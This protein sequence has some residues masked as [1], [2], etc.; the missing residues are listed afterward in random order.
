MKIVAFT[1][2]L[3]A[4]SSGAQAGWSLVGAS[5]TTSYYVD[6]GTV[7]KKGIFTRMWSLYNYAEPIFGKDGEQYS[8]S[9]MH[10]EYDCSEERSKRLFTSVYKKPMGE[11]SALT[12]KHSTPAWGPIPPGTAIELQWKLACDQR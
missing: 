12:L 1:L 4:F 9:I 8:S 2:G 11:G 7:R 3:V 10:V 5:D 6:L